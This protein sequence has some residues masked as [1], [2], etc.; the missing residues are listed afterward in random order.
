[1]MT[2]LMDVSLPCRI[3]TFDLR[4]LD[5]PVPRRA[6]CGKGEGESDRVGG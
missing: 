5:L 3:V 2:S 6:R 1:M 4:N